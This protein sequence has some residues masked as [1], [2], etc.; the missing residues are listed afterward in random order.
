MEKMTKR[1]MY[2]VIAKAAETGV[3]EVETAD[4]VAFTAKEIAA[5]DKKA[6]KARE[7]AAQKKAEG[8]ALRDAVQAVL[9]DE[10]ATIADIAAQVDVEDATVHKI[11]YRLTALVKAGMA[12]KQEVTVEAGEGKKRKVM[13]YRAVQSTC[14]CEGECTC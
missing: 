8:D 2:E 9:T 7:R 1:E 4:I 6:E 13:A 11:T 3:W 12:E 5:L 10:F 14:D